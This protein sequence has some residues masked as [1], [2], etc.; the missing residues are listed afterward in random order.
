MEYENK[1]F[2]KIHAVIQISLRNILY[3]LEQKAN[4]VSSYLN[5]E[6][7]TTHNYTNVIISVEHIPE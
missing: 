2:Y 7:N 3:C 4:C 1:H 5:T 6:G